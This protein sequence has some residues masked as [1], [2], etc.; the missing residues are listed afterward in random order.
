MNQ[1]AMIDFLNLN[2]REYAVIFYITC[3]KADYMGLKLW[4]A[5]FTFRTNKL[6]I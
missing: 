4:Y 6:L 2:Y 3:D 5:V 1:Q